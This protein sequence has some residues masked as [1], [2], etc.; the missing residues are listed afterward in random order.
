MTD[1]VATRRGIPS[2]ALPEQVRKTLF[3][4][5]VTVGIMVAITG[6]LALVSGGVKLGG[7]SMIV[8]L[9]AS[10][11]MIFALNRYRNSSFGLVL[12]AMFSAL[13][14]VLLGP[15]LNHYLEM[16]NGATLVGTAAGLTALATFACAAYA[17]SSKRDF[18]RWAGALFSIT[19]VV[20]VAMIA[21]IFIPIPGLHLALSVVTAVL[22][23]CWLLYDV[24]SILNGTETSY[25]TAALSV[26]LDVLNIFVSLLRIF[27][28]LPGGDD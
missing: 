9:V 26:Y 1:H 24:G 11:A 15:M 16:S 3:N 21:S 8:G 13:H 10:L 2:I 5:F 18:S 20:L 14:G 6:A 19:L 12:L 28:M 23:T 4:T 27:G 22:F 7:L 17:I 25:I